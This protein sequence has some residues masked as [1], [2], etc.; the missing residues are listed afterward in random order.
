[1]YTHP[2]HR[3]TALTRAAGQPNPDFL[4]YFPS[5]PPVPVSSVEVMPAETLDR[6]VAGP[7]GA[8]QFIS[9]DQCMMC[10]SA[11][12]GAYGP[13]MFLQTAP[14]VKGV[15]SGV[16]VSPYGEWRWSPMGLAGR[17]P[18]FFAQLESEIA[19]LKAEFK[20][21]E[22]SI[23]ATVN[24]CLTCHGGMRASA[25]LTSIT[26]TPGQIFNSTS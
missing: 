14:P 24:T 17:D 4:R 16:N 1:M 23:R 6:V 20:D 19:I 9:S 25:S 8:E 3:L 26:K 12:T 5:I 13:V 15:P 2:T 11:A 10:H 7:K 21:P 18:I 22:P